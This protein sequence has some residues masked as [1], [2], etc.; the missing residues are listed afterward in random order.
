MEPSTIQP[1]HNAFALQRTHPPQPSLLVLV[2][3]GPKIPTTRK[4]VAFPYPPPGD[5]PRS[6]Q[7]LATFLT[8][9]TQ[10]YL[11]VLFVFLFFSLGSTRF[12][13]VA[14]ARTK[15][16]LVVVKVFVIHDPSLPLAV[17][18]ERTLKI[19]EQLASAFNCLPYQ[20]VIVRPTYYYQ[21]NI[22][23]YFY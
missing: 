20:R 22:Y 17:H 19:K 2:C 13:K 7:T 16:G 6:P 14:R 8:M 4:R 5:T 23:F 9:G 21:A 1:A 3:R 12:F 18:K 10:H 11:R 15:E